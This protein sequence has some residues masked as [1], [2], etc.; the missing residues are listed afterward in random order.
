MRYMFGFSMDAQAAVGRS[1]IYANQEGLDEDK[2]EPVLMAHEDWADSEFEMPI[3]SEGPQA[4]AAPACVPG[5]S[6]SAMSSAVELWPLLAS[7]TGHPE[8]ESASLRA[9]V[10]VETAPQRLK[11]DGRGMK[12]EEKKPRPKKTRRGVHKIQEI[13]HEAEVRLTVSAPYGKDDPPG[14][15][16]GATYAEWRA[17][18]G[19]SPPMSEQKTK[20][21]WQTNVDMGM[22][23][24]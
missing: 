23:R 12:A 7:S 6:Y 5:H 20:V 9:L 4:V 2:G 15:V 16:Y 10:V 1:R 22:V 8:E 14:R 11:K 17:G 19:G 24:L 21:F 3:A 18:V 13:A